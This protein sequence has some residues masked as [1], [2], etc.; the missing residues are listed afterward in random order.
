MREALLEPE[1]NT[2]GSLLKPVAPI[3]S[4]DDVTRELVAL[5]DRMHIGGSKR[6]APLV[7]RARRTISTESVRRIRRRTPVLTPSIE[8]PS[9]SREAPVLRAK[10]P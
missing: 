10:A 8:P 6:I 1:K 9:R 7:T 2:V 3:N 4:V 5:L